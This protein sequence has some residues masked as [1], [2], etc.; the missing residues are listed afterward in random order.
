MCRYDL[1]CLEGIAQALRVFN[2]QQEVPTYKIADIGK[3]SMLQ[4]HV[5]SEVGTV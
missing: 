5:T 3:S 1:L 4:M 2:K